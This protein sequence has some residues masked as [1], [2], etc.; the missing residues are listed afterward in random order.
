MLCNDCQLSRSPE[1]SSYP[2]TLYPCQVSVDQTRA[3]RIFFG[4]ALPEAL[5]NSD[6]ADGAIAGPHFFPGKDTHSWGW[7]GADNSL[8]HGGAKVYIMTPCTHTH[9]HTPTCGQP[10]FLV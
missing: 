7:L 9:T 5:D 3:G 4:V 10:I 6:D 2:S 8:W 1:H